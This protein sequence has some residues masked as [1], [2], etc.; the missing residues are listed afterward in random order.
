MLKTQFLRFLIAGTVGFAVDAGVLSLLVRGG[1][2]YFEGRALSFLAAVW[3]TW[4][5][6]RRHTFEQRRPQSAWREWWCYLLAMSLGGAIN[7]GA[8]SVAILT[9]PTS[10]Y[11]PLWGVAL[12][13]VAGLAANFASARWWVFGE[14][15]R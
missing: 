9:L 14:R 8:Y 7:Y 15:S 12:G 10:P 5:I 2:G 13:S 6:N 1:A 4:R 3:T 11:L